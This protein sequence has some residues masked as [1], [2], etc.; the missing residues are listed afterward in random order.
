MS[1]D[2]VN[3]WL[4]KF[5]SL[6]HFNSF[7]EETYDDE[8]DDAPISQ[9]AAS[10]NDTFYDHDWLEYYFSKKDQ[11]DL[12]RNIPQIYRHAVNLIIKEKNITDAN[13]IILFYDDWS[14][15]VEKVKS[16]KL[17]HLGQFDE[18][19]LKNS[20][21]EYIPESIPTEFWNDFP[22]TSD[23]IS[24][25]EK[26][27]KTDTASMIKLGIMAL[28]GINMEKDQ[29][30]KDSLFSKANAS[31]V[32]V[33]EALLSVAKCDYAEAWLALYFLCNTEAKDLASDDDRREYIEKAV[34]LGS[35]DA[36]FSLANIL[37]YGWGSDLYENDYDR[38]EELLLSVS[39]F[40]SSGKL[41]VM[42]CLY[43][44][45]KDN[46]KAFIWK[47]RN[48]DTYG[49]S[50][51]NKYIA[52]AYI[53]GK[54]IEKDL[55]EAAKY[56]YLALCQEQLNSFK[57]FDLERL[58]QLSIDELNAGRLL[59]KEWIE[60]KGIAIAAARGR[61]AHFKGEEYDPFETYLKEY[62]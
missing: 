44:M 10:Q 17:W 1:V 22:Q 36:K 7:L 2:T 51:S 35:D 46:K 62:R 48:A 29:K 13:G 61:L 40:N 57:D 6:E 47:K 9:F 4:G 28:C 37:M 12:L 33:K 34:E 18:E 31:P 54:G 11:K 45:K 30:R 14:S 53:D 60:Q 5:N 56:L 16:P 43:S 26:L 20:R 32:M 41:H 52:N 58:K 25:L 24:A 49:G 15:P 42:Y 59:A 23:D 27:A 50:N 38:A 19:F 8:D 39:D 3:I 21:N 55:I